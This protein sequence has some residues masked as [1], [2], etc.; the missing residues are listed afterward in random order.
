[1]ELTINNKVYNFKAGMG[2]LRKANKLVT[3]KVDGTKKE[4]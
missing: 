1:M 3:K 4:K 2:F